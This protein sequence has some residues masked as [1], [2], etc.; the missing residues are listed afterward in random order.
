M[1]KLIAAM[2]VVGCLS[3]ALIGCG[4]PATS[5]PPPSTHP[6]STGAPKTTS[7]KVTD[8][9]KPTLKIKTDAGDEKSFTVPDSVTAD[10]KKDD[11]VT[12]TTDADG[13][14]TKVEK[15]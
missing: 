3:A 2:I 15:K 7:G 5:E 14:V 10:V 8:W 11:T 9:T 12:V 4:P 6:P 13:K 1:K